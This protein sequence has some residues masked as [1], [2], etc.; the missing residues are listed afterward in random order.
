MKKKNLKSLRLAKMS[1][2]NLSH[3][4]KGGTA[5]TNCSI[6]ECGPNDNTNNIVCPVPPFTTICTLN[7]CTTTTITVIE[8]LTLREKTCRFC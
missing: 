7:M 2:S 3:S 5:T 1:I 4:V 8:P 6:H